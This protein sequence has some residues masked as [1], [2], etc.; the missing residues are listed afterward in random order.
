MVAVVQVPSVSRKVSTTPSCHACE[1]GSEGFLF[2]KRHL[3]LLTRINTPD[4]RLMARVSDDSPVNIF[5]APSTSA[6][7]S[8]T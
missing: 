6:I 5:V 1:K 3:Y 4:M 8:N 2:L 7:C